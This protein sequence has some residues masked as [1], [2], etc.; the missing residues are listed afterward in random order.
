LGR[1][2]TP[3]ASAS[4]GELHRD[5]SKLTSQDLALTKG[6]VEMLVKRKLEGDQK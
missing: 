2:D 6:F 4:A 5:L 3:D 1:S